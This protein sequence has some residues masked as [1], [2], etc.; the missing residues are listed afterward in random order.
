MLQSAACSHCTK[1]S[2]RQCRRGT[3]KYIL[4][5]YYG[6]SILLEFYDGFAHHSIPIYRGKFYRLIVSVF[7]NKV[8]MNTDNICC[9]QSI[10]NNKN[11]VD[12]RFICVICGNSGKRETCVKLRVGAE[13][14]LDRT[15]NTL[16]CCVT[17]IIQ[18][19]ISYACIA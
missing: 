7:Y 17:S 12:R 1:I 15:S 19:R 16:L 14:C 5:F 9:S 3:M 2:T 10:V 4:N 13:Y 8:K 6:S 18:Y 11:G